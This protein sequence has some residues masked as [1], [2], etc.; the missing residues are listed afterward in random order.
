MRE[1]QDI[2]AAGSTSQDNGEELRIR[3][4]PGPL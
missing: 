1:A 2:K 4:G 3:E